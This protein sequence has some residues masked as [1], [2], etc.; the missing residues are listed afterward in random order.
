VSRSVRLLGDLH[1]V[2]ADALPWL[3]SGTSCDGGAPLGGAESESDLAEA[4]VLPSVLVVEDE[5]LLREILVLELEDAG[6][7]V[8]MAATGPE[9]VRLAADSSL[10][11]DLV[12]TDIRLGG[13]IDGWDVAEEARVF[14]P[15]VPVIYVTG[16]DAKEPRRVPG[17][18]LIQKPYRPSEILRA[19]RD[20]GVG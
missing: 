19:A 8:L 15:G 18:V 3:A 16:Y 7:Q 12:I 5:A 10:P 14:R 4:P 17:S 1:L 11:V 20:L 2:R 9:G 13:R 6:F